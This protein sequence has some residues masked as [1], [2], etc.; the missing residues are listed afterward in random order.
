MNASRSDI[1]DKGNKLISNSSTKILVSKLER[2]LSE[3]N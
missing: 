2:R 3:V 1:S